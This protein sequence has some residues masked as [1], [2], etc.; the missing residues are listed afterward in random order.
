MALPAARPGLRYKTKFLRMLI[1]PALHTKLDT[2]NYFSL[3]DISV[4]LC[5]D[6]HYNALLCLSLRENSVLLLCSSLFLSSPLHDFAVSLAY[7]GQQH[8]R[9]SVLLL[10]FC[11]C[12]LLLSMC[13]SVLACLCRFLYRR[14]ETY[15]NIASAVCAVTGFCDSCSVS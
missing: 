11:C 7:L 9:L 12:C 10:L 4:L 2:Q 15:T 3:K 6:A 13:F 8:Y 1:T 5:G 14:Y